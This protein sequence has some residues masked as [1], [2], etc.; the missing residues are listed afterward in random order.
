MEE[1]KEEGISIDL[2]NLEFQK[3]ALLSYDQEKQLLPDLKL[4]HG[5]NLIDGSDIFNK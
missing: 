3:H 5:I 4:S 1:L 2:R